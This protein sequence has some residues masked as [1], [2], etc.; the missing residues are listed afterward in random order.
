MLEGQARAHGERLDGEHL[1][2]LVEEDE[3][4][5]D[6][7]GG[8]GRRDGEV[9]PSRLAV[10]AL[11]RGV[12]DGVRPQHLRRR[13][14]DSH[15]LAL[16]GLQRRPR[17]GRDAALGRRAPHLELVN[18]VLVDA[19][20]GVGER[21]EVQVEG[22]ARGL[23]E[24]EGA[25]G[26]REGLVRGEEVAQR[27]GL[28]GGGQ[29]VGRRGADALLGHLLLQLRGVGEEAGAELAHLREVRGPRRVEH[30]V[31]GLELQ[32]RGVQRRVQ[33]A[34]VHRQAADEDALDARRGELVAKALPAEDGHDVRRRVDVL[35]QVGALQA[36]RPRPRQQRAPV[37]L[38]AFLVVGHPAEGVRVVGVLEAAEG[39]DRFVEALEDHLGPSAKPAELLHALAHG[40]VEVRPDAA[41]HAV[42]RE[43]AAARQEGAVLR[44]VVVARGH[45]Q[46]AGGGEL[47]HELEN[48]RHAPGALL[49]AEGAAEGVDLVAG[50]EVVLQV[51]DDEGVAAAEG[52][53]VDVHEVVHARVVCEREP[54]LEERGAVAA[55]LPAVDGVRRRRLL[56]LLG[57]QRR[58]GGRGGRRWRYRGHSNLCG[59]GLRGGGL[60]CGG[61]FGGGLLGRRALG[62]WRVGL[63]KRWGRRGRR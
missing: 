62:C 18:D 19:L 57:S 29:G 45:H 47:L 44:G 25:E 27:R 38:L 22:E 40:L 36:S 2:A 24:G 46:P 42:P 30:H 6:E 20:R 17:H 11:V 8:G 53:G 35:I 16:L 60:R 9:A 55:H 26:L 5:E 4:S 61:L 21:R 48:R 34:E 15:G 51:H 63:G 49:H 59:G 23:G 33:D 1:V 31:D 41:L 37:Q 14:R 28:D 43:V 58:G 56:T 12:V 3:A 13:P 52:E 10:E 32:L 7:E 50:H 54:L 39:V